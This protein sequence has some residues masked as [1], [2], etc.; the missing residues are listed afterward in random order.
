MIKTDLAAV[1]ITTNLDR[2]DDWLTFLNKAAAGD[3]EMFLLG[4]GA[5]YPHPFNFFAYHFCD[6]QFLA[7]G[8]KD[9]QLCTNVSDGLTLQTDA[10][11]LDAYKWASQRIHDTLPLIPLVNVRT[12]LVTR[13][14]ISGAV[15]G[16]FTENY[17]M[18]FV[19]SH[20]A[21]LPAIARP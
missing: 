12:P 3:F 13:R 15:P 19:P 10:L 14:D 1:N 11:R 17:A 16:F 7:L 8:P 6:S 5:D 21:F 18:S 9:T 20:W 4:W 2:Y